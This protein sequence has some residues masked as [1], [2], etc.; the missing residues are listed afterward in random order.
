MRA[1]VASEASSICDAVP[2][3]R[4]PSRRD[5]RTCA[6]SAAASLDADAP[7]AAPF[8]QLAGSHG[9]DGAPSAEFRERARFL[10]DAWWVRS[11]SEPWAHSLSTTV[12]QV[13]PVGGWS[14]SGRAFRTGPITRTA[15]FRDCPMTGR[16]ARSVATLAPI[17][18]MQ[19]PLGAAIELSVACRRRAPTRRSG[20]R[21]CSGVELVR[22]VPLNAAAD[23]SAPDAG[24]PV[25]AAERR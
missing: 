12:P 14:S 13:E 17:L 21:R 1:S 5:V 25:R 23:K 9:E 2:G 19:W 15:A 7:V 11:T 22:R 24:L 20:G 8:L 10:P 4:Q 6:C 16:A 3:A 18:G